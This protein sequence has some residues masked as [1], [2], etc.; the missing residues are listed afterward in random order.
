MSFS[1]LAVERVMAPMYM[2]SGQ[3]LMMD[4][5]ITIGSMSPRTVVRLATSGSELVLAMSTEGSKPASA[6]GSSTTPVEASQGQQSTTRTIGVGQLI[7]QGLGGPTPGASATTSV[8][9]V[10]YV[11]KSFGVSL[12]YPGDKMMSIRI[13]L[14]LLSSALVLIALM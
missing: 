10:E 4:T 6:T 7:N 12:R 5:P 13:E 3:K 14:G 9:G 8:K 11:T 2:I 1:G